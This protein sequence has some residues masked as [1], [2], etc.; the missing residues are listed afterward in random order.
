MHG[1]PSRIRYKMGIMHRHGD[2][3]VPHQCFNP[4]NINPGQRKPRRERVSQA[5]KDNALTCVYNVIVKMQFIDDS[6]E[7][8]TEIFTQFPAADRREN[9]VSY[10]HLTLP[11]T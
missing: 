5:M 2:C 11:T 7:R 4:V 6:A 9:P 3:F 1:V 10:T 8:M